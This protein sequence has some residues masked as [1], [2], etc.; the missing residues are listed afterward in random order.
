VRDDS[1]EGTFLR[2]H[3]HELGIAV[4]QG[5]VVRS[6]SPDCVAGADQLGEPVEIR[7]ASVVMVTQRASESA[8]WE[9][10]SADPAKAAGAGIGGL[11]RIGD[12]VAPRM[13]SEAVFDGHRLAMEIDT[14]D[15]TV[16]LPVNRQERV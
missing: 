3:L 2:Q 14:A 6:V 9:E 13:T 16:A 5:V 1:L 4:R 11:Y 10:L 8:L 7:C 15:P 12:A